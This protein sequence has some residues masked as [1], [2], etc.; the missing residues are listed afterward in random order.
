M[1]KS[2]LIKNINNAVIDITKNISATNKINS[3][4]APITNTVKNQ[5]KD[6]FTRACECVFGFDDS[7][8]MVFGDF[9]KDYVNIEEFLSEEEPEHYS[10]I[11]KKLI[12][13]RPAQIMYTQTLKPS[14]FISHLFSHGKGQGK[15]AVKNVVK[16]SLE[17]SRT[18]GRVTLQSDIIDGK[19]SPSGFYYKLG[20][21]FA[22]DDKNKLLQD[23]INKGGNK[24]DA[25]MITG[26]MYLPKENICQCLN[27]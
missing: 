20:F 8:T 23:W 24:A 22:V 6:T 14:Y 18:Q 25:P 15:E 3:K 12:P 13:A 10:R 4:H 26:L 16:K 21:R 1:Y 7:K 27:Y 11:L 2:D 9:P 19:T 5:T 17:D